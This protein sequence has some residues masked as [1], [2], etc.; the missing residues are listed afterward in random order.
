VSPTHTVV[1]DGDSTMLAI[2][3]PDTVTGT[4]ARTVVSSTIFAVIVADPFA[5]ANTRPAG[6]TVAM[7]GFDDD[8]LTVG[9]FGFLSDAVSFIDCP[10]SSV[11]DAGWMNTAGGRGSVESQAALRGLVH[12]LEQ[13]LGTARAR[14]V[15]DVCAVLDDHARVALARAGLHLDG[16]VVYLDQGLTPA[17]I[18]ARTRPHGVARPGPESA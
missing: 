4:V 7:R 13:G 17:A 11:S 8:Q 15:A 16:P 1:D 14:D 2:A 9:C 6:S 3:G 12:R 18:T 10:S 5:T